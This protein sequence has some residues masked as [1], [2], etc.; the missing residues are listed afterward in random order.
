M[1]NEQSAARAQV[2]QLQGQLS[3]AENML[4]ATTAGIG[5]VRK[6]S[7]ARIAELEGQLKLAQDAKPK[8]TKPPLR[9]IKTRAIR[10]N[11]GLEVWYRKKLQR[12]IEAMAR[13]I[14]WWVGAAYRAQEPR[15]DLANDAA[16]A[17]ILQRVL[18]SLRK[19]W[20]QRFDDLGEEIAEKFAQRAGDQTDAA[21]T[22]AMRAAGMRIKFQ[23][24]QAQKDQLA[25]TV[26]ENVALI[27]S[28]P[29]QYL[30]AV[31]GHVMRAI[32]AGG[33]LGTL[34]TELKKAY[35]ITHRRAAFIA[36]DQNS[37]ATAYL[38]R[39]RQLSVGITQAQWVHSGGGGP[40]GPRM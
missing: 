38:N 30:G 4:R 32:L 24:T 11:A 34:T 19:R 20:G 36:R 40:N 9:A 5:R 22:A 15:I 6:S 12:E 21:V 23:I 33:D 2:A 10:P 29:A 1:D 3:R 17:D 35:G 26:N 28:I 14:E 31:E 13:S 8:V 27:R 16:P 37:K 7:A 25:A 39:S 18:A